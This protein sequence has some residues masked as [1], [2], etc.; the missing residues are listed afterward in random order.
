[1]KI[2]LF[3]TRKN[4][5][6]S[7]S[8][9]EHNFRTIFL[10]ITCLLLIS[11]GNNNPTK[12]DLLIVNGK[13]IDGTG[14]AG[15][16]ADV[17]VKG[18]KIVEINRLGIE[19]E[20][21]SSVIDARGMVVSPGFIDHHAHI[22]HTIQE[23]PLAENFI[24]QGITTIL[25]SLHSGSQPWPFGKYL[26][27]LDMSPNVGYF[28]GFN[29]TREQVLGLE[30]REPTPSELNE[31]KSLVA[32]TMQEGALGLASGLRYVPGS[33]ANTDEVVELAKVAS[34]YG[35]Y[36]V[37]HIRNEGP[38]VVEAVREVIEIADRANLPAQ[39]QHH[40]VMGSEQWGD[41]K[42]TLGIID[43]ARYNGLKIALDV[44]PYSATSTS[45]NVLFPGW[46]LEGGRDSLR[47]RLQ[48]PNQ[49][50]RI[51]EGI[52]N[53]LQYE[54]GGGDLERIQF[55]ELKSFPEYTGKTMADMARDR[56]M[57]VNLESGIDLAIELQLKGGFSG[58]WHVLDEKDVIDIIQYPYT[59]FNSDGDLVGFGNGHPHPRSYGAFPR[60]INKYVE[61]LKVLSLSD[62]IHRM[63]DMSAQWIGQDN[64]GRI[65]EGYFAD[66]IV[67]D[68]ETLKDKATYTD[69]HQFSTGISHVIINGVS[70]IKNASL[71]GKR[72][73]KILW[74]PS[75]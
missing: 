21:A 63:T 48:D 33:F 38:G 6:E 54:R 51:R 55:R 22:Q 72:P 64:R 24:R 53:R 27:Q 34:E 40:K 66:I 42:I 61:G 44:Y 10:F 23:H 28:A 60:V 45:S 46:A 67:F 14:E 8:E 47:V 39:I 62:A 20:K 19:K 69:P 71:T 15:F 9:R 31:M 13:V 68:P 5:P 41:S 17:A 75:R 18:D 65:Q 3:K 57:P 32:R 11:C 58:I 7:Y 73:G 16:K 52:R 37:S 12:Y 35:G 43:S 4:T 70:V 50:R 36:Y 59:M 29:W 1:M 74:G 2:G 25:A 49:K 26:E 30:D 56:N